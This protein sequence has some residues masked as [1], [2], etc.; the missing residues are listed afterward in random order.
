MLVDAQNDLVA[1]ETSLVQ[2]TAELS[3][4]QS[5]LSTKN[6]QLDILESSLNA[7][8]NKL[9]LVAPYLSEAPSIASNGKNISLNFSESIIFGAS[10]QNAFEVITNGDSKFQQVHITKSTIIC[11]LILLIRFI[12]PGSPFHTTLRP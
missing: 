2:K 4:V 8:E 3:S 6:T 9:Q 1:A 7:A 5:E 10:A 12:R 11:I